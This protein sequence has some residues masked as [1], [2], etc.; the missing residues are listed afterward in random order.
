M[1]EVWPSEVYKINTK[2]QKAS[3]INLPLYRE[4][5]VVKKHKKTQL[6][7]YFWTL[8]QW[9]YWG[10]NVEFSICMI[11]ISYENSFSFSYQFQMLHFRNGF[12][13]APAGQPKALLKLCIF[14]S[15]PLTLCEDELYLDSTVKFLR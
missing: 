4:I 7:I 6:K 5:C 12:I 8:H 14:D 9:I 10:S 15:A 13:F 11:F 1:C 3:L 2:F